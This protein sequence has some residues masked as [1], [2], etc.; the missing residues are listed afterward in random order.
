MKDEADELPEEEDEGVLVGGG[1]FKVDRVR[2]L[3]LMGR[4]RSPDAGPVMFLARAAS[5]CGA[6][7]FSVCRRGAALE[8]SF[9]GTPFSHAELADP[10][11]ALF[12]GSSRAAAR[13]LAQA[14]LHAFRPGLSELSVTSGSAAASSTLKASGTASETVEQD[15]Q[16]RAGTIIRLLCA[17]RDDSLLAHPVPAAEIACRP[18]SH[19]WGRLPSEFRVD[20]TLVGSYAPREA[21]PGEIFDTTPNGPRILL[22]FLPPPESRGLLDLYHHGVYAG[23]LRA[24]DGCPDVL[25]KVDDP[26]LR[27]NASHTSL[28]RSPRLTELKDRCRVLAWDLVGKVAAEQVERMPA[29][30]ALLRSN[31]PLRE[32]WRR[33]FA[34]GADAE[35][36]LHES[37]PLGPQENQVLHDAA[38]TSWLRSV[39]CQFGDKAALR[40]REA[41]EKAPLFLS[42][43]FQTLSSADLRGRGNEAKAVAKLGEGLKGVWAETAYQGTLLRKLR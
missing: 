43:G 16:P 36:D 40:V 2:A 39:A 11:G 9:D 3:E 35:L 4:Y 24:A 41:L 28:V 7:R 8:V 37:G 17:R 23:R 32:L 13:F 1:S 42:T 22:A 18:Q 27:L 19:F 10:Y 34:R 26:E 25:G 12:E 15:P 33:R 14:L 20:D 38:A 21:G 31:K 5:A 6:S 29:T 30:M